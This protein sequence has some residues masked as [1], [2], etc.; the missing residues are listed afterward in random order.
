M[1][2]ELAISQQEVLDFARWSGDRN[3][4]HVDQEAAKKSAFGGTI[5]HGALSTIEAIRVGN[6]LPEAN[7]LS[8][9]DIEFRS[10]LRPG[11]TYALTESS[12]DSSFNICVGAPE[13]PQLLIAAT[14]SAVPSSTSAETTVGWIAAARESGA[15]SSGADDPVDW[16][17]SQF[18]EG[19]E[20]YGIHLFDTHVAAS[21]SSLT[22]TQEQVLALCSFIVGMKVPGLSSLFTKLRIEFGSVAAQTEFSD[23][24]AYRLVP[25]SYDPHFRILE[26]RLEIATLDGQP[27]ANAT[28]QSYVRFRQSTSE[29][30]TYSGHVSQDFS[31]K[32]ALVCGAS[33]GLGAEIAAAL[34]AA[35][36]HVYLACRN[37]N[38]AVQ[39]L[40]ESIQEHGGNAEILAGD[41]GNA[42]W[43]SDTKEMLHEKHGKLD[44]LVLNACAPPIPAELQSNTAAA[45]IEYIAQNIALAQTP[46][47]TFLPLIAS[48]E[49]NVVGISSSF[50]KETPAGF[51][52][53]I[54]V[55][56]ALEASLKTAAQEHRATKF[57][58]ARP[59]KL[60]TTWNDTPTSAMGAIP[61]QAAALRIVQSI[62]TAS[63]S[64]L[65]TIDEFPEDAP[66]ARI[67]L[68][69]PDLEIV[70]CSSFTIDPFTD[71]FK[72]WSNELD[73]NLAVAQTP[74]A[75]ILQQALDPSS[76]L[77]T[78]KN[79]SVILLRVSDWLREMPAEQLEPGNLANWL[80][81]TTQE[82]IHALKTHR[83]HAAS[84]TLLLLCPSSST[85]ELTSSQ[86]QQVEN[87]LH[88]ELLDVPGL[89]IQ[90][91]SKQHKLYAVDEDGIFDALREDIAHI[92]FQNAYYF[93]LSTLIVRHF[94]RRLAAPIKVVV[95]DCD[96]TLWTGVVGEVGPEGLQ[97]SSV[98]HRLH[99]RL[100]E[101][102]GCGVL[103][104]LCS[105][106]EEADVWSAFEAR[107]D[108]GLDRQTIVAAAINWLP[109]SQNIRQLA[110]DL[111]L[112]LD[113]FV[114]LDDNPVECAEVRSGCP[115]VLTLQWP[116][117]E[118]D[119]GNLF[120]HL[121]ELDPHASTAEDK[122]RTQRYK[123]EFQRQQSRQS[124]G[125]FQEF[126]DS[127][128][129]DTDLREL[130]EEDLPRASQ[131]TMRTNQFNFTTIRRTEAELKEL[132]HDEAFACYTMR[133]S[134]RFG[135]Y[136]LVGFMIGRVDSDALEVDTFLISCR[137][138]G[139][140]VEHR[141]AS[142]LGKFAKEQ[143][144]ALV[145]WEHSPTE[146]NTP[147]RMFLGKICSEE[148]PCSTKTLIREIA[149]ENLS[150]FKLQV[151]IE[152]SKSDAPTESKEPVATKKSESRKQGPSQ[153]EREQQ[154]AHIRARLASYSDML[155]YCGDEGYA[156][157][158][159]AIPEAEDRE[160]VEQIVVSAFA[161]KL[162]LTPEVIQKKDRL[163]ALGCDSLRIVEITIQLTKRFAW[164]PKTLLF[165]HRSIS[166][167]IEQIANL[168]SQTSSGHAPTV[169][170]TQ[171][172]AT[173]DIAIV[174]IDVHC[175]AG[176]STQQLWDLLAEGDSAIRQVP[177][178][179]ESFVGS[180]KD[181]RPHFAGLIDD[182][183]EFDAEFFGISPREAE[184]LDPQLRLLVQSG[185]RALE[186]AGASGLE[187]DASV[188]VFVGVMYS[189]YARFANA[190]ATQTGGVYRCWEGFSLA[191]RLSQIIG[192]SGP[193]L[194]I[195]TACSS[196]ATAL[197]YACN[198]L[199]RGDCKV[200]LVGGV[201]LI[202]DPNRLAQLGRLGILS[203]SGTCVPF[204]DNADGTV[205]GEGAVTLAIRSL[206]DAIE[207][208]DRI[209]SVIKGT[210]ISSGAGSVGFTAPNPVAQSVAA[211]AALEDAAVD[212]RTISYIETHGTGTELG[213]PIEVRGLEMAY[214]DAALQDSDLKIQP[215]C[216][217]GS[218]K[219]NVGHLEAGAGLM[220]V[221]KAA[222]QLH[223]K[224]LVP[225]I[226]SPA[227]NPQIPF[228]QLPFRVQSETSPWEKLAAT[229]SGAVVDTPRRAG[230]NSFGVGG[231]NVHVILEEAPNIAAERDTSNEQFTEER[232]SHVVALSSNTELGLARQE[233]AWTQFLAADETHAANS[234]FSAN[235]GRNHHSLR[236]CVVADYSAGSLQLTPIRQST[237]ESD[238]ANEF[239]QLGFLFTGQGAQ[240]PTMLGNLY[241]T[242][243]VFRQAFDRCATPLAELLPKPIESVIFSGALDERE[244]EIHQTGFT[245]PALF[246]IQYSLFELWSS[247]GVRP[248]VS[249]G[250]SIGEVAAYC[251]AGGC[252]LEDA[253]RLVAARGQLMQALP[254]GGAMCSLACTREQAES[255]IAELR[256]KVS[257]AA[258]NGPK[259]TV[260]SGAQMQVERLAEYFQKKEVKTTTLSV[261]HAFHSDLMDPML[262]DFAKV[263]DRLDLGTPTQKIISSATGKEVEEE[264]SSPEYWLQQARNPVLFLDAMETIDAFGINQFVEIGPHPVML[265][266]GRGCLPDS[267]AGWLPSA[268]R[269]QKDWS[270]IS[271]SVG[272][273]YA[274]GV[275]I[276]WKEYDKP[277][278]RQ[279]VS[280]PGYRFAKQRVWIEEL[281]GYSGDSA[282]LPAKARQANKCYEIEWIEKATS[283]VA[284]A[285]EEL[286][287]LILANNAPTLNRLE[288]LLASQSIRARFALIETDDHNIQQN[289]SK[290]AVCNSQK[291]LDEL[292][293]EGFDRIVFASL[294]RE[295]LSVAESNIQAV[296]AAT[297]LVQSIIVSESKAKLWLLT[298]NAV[299]AS[300]TTPDPQSAS[301]WGLSRVGVLEH[302]D[303]WGGIVDVEDLPQQI[304]S[305]IQEI[306]FP[307][308]EDQ[309]ALRAA[310]RF[311]PRL[312]E[313]E[314][315][316]NP[317]DWLQ[318]LDLA[319]GSILITGGLGGLGLRIAQWLSDLGAQS[320]VL[321][322]RSG[323]PSETAKKFISSIEESGTTVD[324]VAADV[325]TASGVDLCVSTAS[326]SIV[327]VFHA[328][329]ID[330]VQTLAASTPEDIESILSAKVRGAQL[331][332]DKCD[333]DKLKLVVYFSSISAIWGSIHRASYAAANSFLDA[334]AHAQNSPGLRAISLNFGP[335][336]GGGMADDASLAE[337]ERIGN[338][339]LDPHDTLDTMSQL[340]HAAASQTVI[341][342][343][344]WNQ[345]RPT[346]ESRRPK[347]L[348]EKLGGTTPN[349]HAA[350]S[351]S[352]AEWVEL[353]RSQAVELRSQILEDAIR[354]E[355]ARL[356]RI[357]DPSGIDTSKSLFDIGLDSLT[358]AELTTRLRA[359]AG[360]SGTSKLLRN[361]SIHGIAEA[362][363]PQI[364][365]DRE[366]TAPANE[367]SAW[368]STLESVDALERKRVLS[369]LL[370][371]ELG[372]MLR[373]PTDEHTSQTAPADLGL[374]SL[375]SVE[376]A[377]RVRDQLGLTKAPRVLE[378]P[379]LDAL[380]D[381][382]AGEIPEPEVSE[383]IGYKSDIE[384][385]LFEFVQ[386]AWPHRRK[387]W[388]EPRWKWM[389]LE[390]AK[391]IN[392]EPRVWLYRDEEEIVGHHGAQFVRF[393][394][395]DQEVSTAWFVETMVQ[396]SHRSHGVGTRLVM[397]SLEDMPLNLSLGQSA[398]MRAILE[399]LGW[400][401]VAPLQTYMY[402]IHPGR[403]LKGKLPGVLT[404]VASAWLKLR[405]NARR[406]MQANTSPSGTVSEV[407]E[408]DEKHDQLWERVASCYGN[409]TVRDASFLNWKYI[410]QPGQE[411]RCIDITVDGKL[412][413]TAALLF[414]EP[415]RAYGYRRAY[416]VDL[417]TSTDLSTCHVAIQTVLAYCRD[418]EAHAVVMHIINTPIQ[419][420]L[421]NCGFLRRE[422]T[423]HLLVATG[424]EKNADLLEPDR[425]LVT[426]GDSDIDRPW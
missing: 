313:K 405:S 54:S 4:I 384:Q 200:A 254:S 82:H 342:D 233:E 18:R 49:G 377:N 409:A 270:I 260:V 176:D 158:G 122:K 329:G 180:L 15:P 423:R 127:L 138:L 36:C 316:P 209:Y 359:L 222:L 118:T 113:S 273:L 232:S 421:E 382:L 89:Q 203:P 80:D 276:D 358:S 361:P 91:A 87:E 44:Y 343:V 50:V 171:A 401:N 187:F 360:N 100:T 352:N 12:T 271:E 83:S 258:I 264:M 43:C 37:P 304:G 215:D 29:P 367:T 252:S 407:V 337:L 137:V 241:T 402:P 281:E 167:I 420:A 201:N 288:G 251:T 81:E 310:T 335:W 129:L 248:D 363:L 10:E 53:Y 323:Q 349:Q 262:D 42:Q 19:R 25:Q 324:I 60:Q 159:V 362:I 263:L 93:F 2:L 403:V 38:E 96:N 92:P 375:G 162:K 32:V 368:G 117:D 97:F 21:D 135:D 143:S 202:I 169:K 246:T 8:E 144:L 125:S 325:S 419:Q 28:M 277:Y 57:I 302:S 307:S 426:Q 192:A 55:K 396:E 31:E 181:D 214:C 414:A 249:M 221:A 183:A 75:Q 103:I 116:Q 189:G 194:S 124:A 321:A 3:P 345:F 354:G 256:T 300:G 6:N 27:V 198:S 35:K 22:T 308:N 133:V 39:A 339:G 415:D 244:H 374:D 102:A 357:S 155:A 33:R 225:S 193:S 353:L 268:R 204:G 247:W 173:T 154:I 56:N 299:P 218:I 190:I 322:S 121:W 229:R 206:S 114:F 153:R 120:D 238:Q 285:L 386:R 104:C 219:P 385:K 86:I 132:M 284:D 226:T 286:S 417:V 150:E 148:L 20:S 306:R 279:R 196:S 379:H 69:D 293:A 292:V 119:A 334:L 250:H 378:Y 72:D 257:I 40:A 347:P 182:A 392:S 110:A 131:L 47:I 295:E 5:I 311:V 394:M 331:L 205:L 227:P 48:S 272:R 356:L 237:K 115:E 61:T 170:A 164:L 46:L 350:K 371:K 390:S 370:C 51:S 24:L 376:F 88:G 391:R 404:P 152:P 178:T 210:G 236:G 128:E 64:N 151:E 344:D 111:N 318:D 130:S 160:Q 416:L 422:P 309:I 99:Q 63:Y 265:A 253:L 157:T 66:Q 30:S 303:W 366:A 134:D 163:D 79:G 305:C 107:E 330:K 195:D 26:T 14:R 291:Q 16:Q 289:S 234:C 7:F 340:I 245:Q 146:R 70:L 239:P 139:R 297:Q 383:I 141:M 224:T 161:E 95:L 294:S 287:W 255:A 199:R 177:G 267:I 400:H 261:S 398:E 52:D 186:D 312:V 351:S 17:P 166:D 327:A 101:L 319:E 220:G 369:D 71:C 140:G 168:S 413:A 269:G 412:I 126:I 259:Q 142:E 41:V 240:Y 314:L 315:A 372:E 98:Q 74:Y 346:F 348:L 355:V 338:F 418:K 62:G 381:A 280:V 145:R 223:Q 136:G 84:P 230:V 275:D 34:G 67:Q 58:I 217:I 410:E 365:L 332:S 228:S 109:K 9:L 216:A 387:D 123:E 213:D 333:A 1:A 85:E 393:K 341:A 424:K 59:P 411:Y 106:N 156:G 317:G 388:I 174:G 90:I 373:K 76:Q 274:S 112:G 45:S 283:A 290:Y 184:Y 13:Q 149:A 395:G 231:T 78:S 399:K 208:G 108:F 296:K 425:W 242:N 328:A 23:R 389:Y 188:G 65:E 397:Q 243:S 197:H 147:A 278:Q 235:I 266:M 282:P 179:R 380:A 298:E 172:D 165:E 11:G 211:R 326:E 207:R 68:G 406:W 77:S 191:N 94:H 364:Q 320:L 185:W 212:P 336:A 408:F 73:A 175:A 301:L 105:K